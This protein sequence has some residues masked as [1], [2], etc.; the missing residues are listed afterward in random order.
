MGLLKR[1]WDKLGHLFSSEKVSQLAEIKYGKT[2]HTCHEM[3]DSKVAM[4]LPWH[5]A[6]VQNLNATD[7]YPS[8]A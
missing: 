5:G 7:G 3:N 8:L 6:F 2:I 4:T 1:V